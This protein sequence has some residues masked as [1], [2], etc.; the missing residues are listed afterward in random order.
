MQRL[1]LR[2]HALNPAPRV[3]ARRLGLAVFDGRLFAVGGVDRG[4]KILS[5]VETL[6]SADGTWAT[7]TNAL[8]V[9]RAGC[10]GAPR[11]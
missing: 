9:P 6:S 7:E 11:P 2:T 3:V 5:S 4:D 10:V 1:V 8:N